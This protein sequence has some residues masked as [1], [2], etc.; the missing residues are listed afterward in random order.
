MTEKFSVEKLAVLRLSA[1]YF[2]SWKKIKES[3]K[4]A[5]LSVDVPTIKANENF[6]MVEYRDLSSLD[7]EGKTILESLIEEC[8]EKFIPQNY[9]EAYKLR[10]KIKEF[11]TDYAKNLF[12]LVFK[13]IKEERKLTGEERLSLLKI[14]FSPYS[15][16]EELAKLFNLSVEKKKDVLSLVG[17]DARISPTETCFIFRR[18]KDYSPD[19]I[20]ALLFFTDF[21]A[22]Y[23]PYSGILFSEALEVFEFPKNYSESTIN[24]AEIFWEKLERDFKNEYSIGTAKISLT[25]FYCLEQDGNAALIYLASKTKELQEIEFVLGEKIKLEEIIKRASKKKKFKRLMPLIERAR[26]SS[27]AYQ[28]EFSCLEYR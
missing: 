23:F 12:P 8:G 6:L 22:V 9:V 11:P 14:L 15:F 13:H 20:S 7:G 1:E 24:D 16:Q 25:N 3:F 19:F 5:I 18:Q 10:K 26:K 27:R 28:K 21:S 4:N 17:I 2:T